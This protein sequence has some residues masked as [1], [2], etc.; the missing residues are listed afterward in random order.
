LNL[1]WSVDTH[2]RY[3]RVWRVGRQ[4]TEAE[5]RERLST[6]PGV[7]TG[8]FDFFLGHLERAREARW[9]AFKALEYRGRS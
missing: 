3:G 2:Y 9:F 8:R 4:I 7:F 6:L 5:I 1:A